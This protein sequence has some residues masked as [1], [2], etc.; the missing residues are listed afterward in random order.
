MEPSGGRTTAR[1]CATVGSAVNGAIPVLA[2]DTFRLLLRVGYQTDRYRFLES[3][4]AAERV[5]DIH[6]HRFDLNVTTLI[7]LS[8]RWSVAVGGGVSLAGD[9]QS[10]SADAWFPTGQVVAR[11]AVDPDVQLSLGVFAS[12]N[13][14]G[15][16]DLPVIVLPS[17]GLTYRPRGA[18]WALEVSFPR[19]TEF[20]WSPVLDLE[21]YA[22]TSFGG[23]FGARAATATHDAYLFTS[24]EIEVSAGLRYLITSGLDLGVGFGV[25]PFR[26][27]Q[28]ILPGGREPDRTP[29]GV[30]YSMTLQLALRS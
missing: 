22:Q 18:S 21:V 5:D 8:R 28:A 17:F 24:T 19:L 27:I 12:R 30:G 15:V 1:P 25:Q 14:T 9:L 4:T 16:F 13:T 10:V 26:E 7:P 20:R 11:W 6:M 2:R 29:L 23:A 3:E